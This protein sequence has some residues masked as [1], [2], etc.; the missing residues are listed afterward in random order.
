MLMNGTHI[1]C[2]F[3]LLTGADTHTGATAGTVHIGD[4]DTEVVVRHTHKGH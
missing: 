3:A 4:D 1:Q 2:L